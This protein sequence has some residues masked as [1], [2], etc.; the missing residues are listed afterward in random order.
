L[1]SPGISI[2]REGSRISNIPP[3]L[4]EHLE[5]EKSSKKTTTFWGVEKE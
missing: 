3:E 2:A 5:H 4:K 1:I